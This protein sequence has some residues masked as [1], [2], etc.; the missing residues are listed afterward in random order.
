M[1]KLK[2][3]KVIFF[4]VVVVAIAVLI[5]GATFILRN[6]KG[7]INNSN[8]NSENISK[9]NENKNPNDN[10]IPSDKDTNFDFH[11]DDT[12]YEENTTEFI[13]TITNKSNQPKYLNE[14]FIQLESNEES[15]EQLRVYGIV[16]KELASNETITI[17]CTYG[18]DLK[19]YKII[20]YSIEK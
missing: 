6:K 10:F 3:K 8:Q 19:N 7:L 13:V 1:E 16:E 15:K 14:F 11:L 4:V 12:K 17:N 9:E 2:N 20:G 5:I 18:D